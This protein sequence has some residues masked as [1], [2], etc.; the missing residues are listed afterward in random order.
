MNQNVK[1]NFFEEHLKM[2]VEYQVSE[3]ENPDTREI[4]NKSYVKPLQAH[5]TRAK[6]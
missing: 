6:I 4:L 5:H 3:K 1:Q 2:T